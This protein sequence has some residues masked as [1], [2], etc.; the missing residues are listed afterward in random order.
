MA[1][2]NGHSLESMQACA[3]AGAC[4]KMS[5]L[6]PTQVHAFEGENNQLSPR[7]LN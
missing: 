3:A 4:A 7:A 5:H 1:I 6:T 2:G